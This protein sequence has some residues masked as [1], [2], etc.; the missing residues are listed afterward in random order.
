MPI[1][2][3]QNL[4]DVAKGFAAEL[5]ISLNALVVLALRDYLIKNAPKVMITKPVS[6]PKSVVQKVGRNELCPCG[7]GVKYKRCHGAADAASP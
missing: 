4:S 5:G 6:H 3:P 2:L 7:S 1:R